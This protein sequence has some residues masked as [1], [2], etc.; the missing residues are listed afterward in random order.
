VRIPKLDVGAYEQF[1]NSV[2][3]EEKFTGNLSD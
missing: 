1:S 2:L 3:G